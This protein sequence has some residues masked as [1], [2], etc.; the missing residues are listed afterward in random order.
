[1]KPRLF[2][3]GMVTEFRVTSVAVVAKDMALRYEFPTPLVVM[4]DWARLS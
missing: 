3:T 1:M 2:Q 4:T